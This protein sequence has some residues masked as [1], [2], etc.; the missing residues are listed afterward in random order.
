M[1]YRFF[2][3]TGNVSAECAFFEENLSLQEHDFKAPELIDGSWKG[4]H[5]PEEASYTSEILPRATSTGKKC[6]W[7]ID[8][9]SLGKLLQ[10]IYPTDSVAVMPKCLESPMKRMLSPDHR[11]RPTCASI[12]KAPCFHT[13][14]LKLMTTIC[15][16]QLKP[17]LE[18]IDIFVLLKEKV[19]L[20]SKAVCTFKVLACIGNMLSRSI[21]DFQ[22][23]DNR[24]TCRRIV[25]SSLDLLARFSEH[26]KVDDVVFSVSCLGPYQQ[27]WTFSDRAIRTA[28][29]RTLK[30]ILFL[31]SRDVVN[32]KLFEPLL[33]GF[34]DSNSKLR[35]DTLKS[36]VFVVEKLDENQLQDKL[37][38]C[39]CNLQN[40]A[41][42]SVRTNSIIFLSRIS[43][44]LTVAVR[45]RVLAGSYCKAMKDPFLH[46]RIAG[47]KATEASISYYDVNQIC[48][49]LIPQISLLLLDKSHDVNEV[50]NTCIVM[51]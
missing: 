13:E 50:G 36:L 34:S 33:A 32:R 16:L 38:R 24:E 31:L 4:I 26:H 11:R 22:V 7:S 6:G 49:R 29:L 17:P 28:L 37:V 41:E 48:T 21:A 44:K 14:E 23:R 1:L 43:G 27:L 9:F 45:Q 51:W 25:H 8:M 46:C 40:D 35:E 19:D 12:L 5:I 3:L 39:I 10:A 42:A 47:L 30:P 15:E 2:V 18:C 20:I